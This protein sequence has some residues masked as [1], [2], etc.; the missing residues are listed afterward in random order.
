MVNSLLLQN[1]FIH[2]W[3]SHKWNHLVLFWSGFLYSTSC[4]WDT[5]NRSPFSA[6]DEHL[7]CFWLFAITNN[8]AMDIL[9]HAIL[10]TWALISP[11]IYEREEL[12]VI[13]L[14]LVDSAGQFSRAI[15]PINNSTNRCEFQLLH[16]L[17][18]TWHFVGPFN[19]T[20]SFSYV[21]AF[22]VPWLPSRVTT[23]LWAIGDSVL[24]NASFCL[25]PTFL[26]G[27]LSSYFND[28]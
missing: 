18:N 9:A 12:L 4:L 8:S 22:Y 13:C 19:I 16:I 6:V 7:C 27:C 20:W 2:S 15:I 3:T 1:R 26:W 10:G 28:F 21:L 23:C 25:L 14:T 5:C 11:G 17:S 24:W